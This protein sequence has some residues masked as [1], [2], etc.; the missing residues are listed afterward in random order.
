MGH[1]EKNQF[2]F[3]T[4]LQRDLPFLRS[5]RYRDILRG[6]LE[7][8]NIH[9]GERFNDS[10]W[11]IWCLDSVYRCWEEMN[12]TWW[13]PRAN[14]AGAEFLNQNT[15]DD[16][17]WWKLLFEKDPQC[18]DTMIGYKRRCEEISRMRTER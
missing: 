4:A 10:A 17:N 11:W 8:N 18:S 9:R 14:R 1:G 16:V 5:I 12:T 13:W 2:N 7:G 6:D 15:F 3:F